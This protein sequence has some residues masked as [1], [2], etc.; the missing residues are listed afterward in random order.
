MWPQLPTDWWVYVSICM[1]VC[2]S[3][4]SCLY[5][6]VCLCVCVFVC[7][8]VCV[9]MYL[10]ICVCVSVCLC[11]YISVYVSPLPI[12]TFWWRKKSSKWWNLYLRPGGRI[13]AGWERR[14]GRTADSVILLWFRPSSLPH[15]ARKRDIPMVWSSFKDNIWRDLVYL[16]QSWDRNAD[17]KSQYPSFK[18]LPTF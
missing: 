6:S 2:V 5:V 8:C 10:C 15:T 1:C 14:H 9:C 4:C 12:N 18:H 16:Q 3:V 17:N 7:L 13:S 11:V